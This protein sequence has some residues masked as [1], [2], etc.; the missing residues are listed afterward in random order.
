MKVIKLGMI[1]LVVFGLL[2]WGIT[3]MFPSNTIVSRVVNIAGNAD[4]MHRKVISNEISLQTLLAGNESGLVVK[5]ADI[6]FYDN[7]LFNTLSVG[8]LPQADT[9]FFQVSKSGKMIA[10][11]GLAFYQLQADSTTTQFFYVFQ[12]PWYKPLLKMK[13]MMADK[14]YGPGLDSCLKRLKLQA[15]LP[16]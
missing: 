13:M 10:Q 4:S 9:I 15:A 7:N 11:G 3:L 12:T 5:D 8:S 14:V 6:P 1:S 16:Q 2:F